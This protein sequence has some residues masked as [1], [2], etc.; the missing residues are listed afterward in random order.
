[1][2]TL[3]IAVALFAATPALAWT[4][5]GK[6]LEEQ[7]ARDEQN[8]LIRQQNET[9]RSIEIEQGLSPHRDPFRRCNDDC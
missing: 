2:K 4:D 7:N 6:K 1:M 5:W 3:L 8:D 9:L